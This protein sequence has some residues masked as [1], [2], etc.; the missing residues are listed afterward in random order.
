[1]ESAMG[2]WAEF[3]SLNGTLPI[4]IEIRAAFR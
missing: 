1:M 3:T 4:E 2:I